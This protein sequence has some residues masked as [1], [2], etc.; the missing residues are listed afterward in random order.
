MNLNILDDVKWRMSNTTPEGKGD[1]ETLAMNISIQR[2]YT[3]AHQHSPKRRLPSE[4]RAKG[5]HKCPYLCPLLILYCLRYVINSIFINN[6][7]T[8]PFSPPSDLLLAL[9]SYLLD[10]E[11]Y[12]KVPQTALSCIDTLLEASFTY[13]LNTHAFIFY[14]C[15]LL[16][17]SPPNSSIYAQGGSILSL[18]NHYNAL[19]YSEVINQYLGALYVYYYDILWLWYFHKQTDDYLFAS[20][21]AIIENL[22]FSV[23]RLNITLTLPRV[24]PNIIVGAGTAGTVAAL[25]ISKKESVLVIEQGQYLNYNAVIS[26]GK[27]FPTYALLKYLP[28]EAGQKLLQYSASVSIFGEGTK[29]MAYYNINS[30]KGSIE[31]PR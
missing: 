6:K 11:E 3:N 1:I 2:V 20:C 8:Y 25:E 24:Y 29:Y 7:M 21:R 4:R 16:Y 14:N 12:S 13:D 5:V 23:P 28:K 30:R 26:F 27:L 10:P 9:Q 22:A 17:L 15:P 31:Y 19:P 18:F